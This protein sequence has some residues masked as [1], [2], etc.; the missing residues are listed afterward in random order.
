MQFEDGFDAI[1]HDLVIVNE[2]DIEGHNSLGPLAELGYQIG[3]VIVY[4][5]DLYVG[6]AAGDLAGSSHHMPAHFFINILER[7]CHSIQPDFRVVSP[8][9]TFHHADLGA[10]AGAAITGQLQRVFH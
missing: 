10:C 2:Q 5:R 1:A 8:C 6:L 9:T 3:R 4:G 7:I